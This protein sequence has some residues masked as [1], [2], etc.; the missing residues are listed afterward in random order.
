MSGTYEDNEPPDFEGPGD[1][2]PLANSL[3]QDGFSA[4]DGIPPVLP[5]YK[6]LPGS[7]VPVSSKRGK[8]W[9]ARKD[10]GQKAM[11]DL[12][13]AWDECI[14]YY[15]HDQSDHREGSDNRTAGNRYLARRLNDLFSST[16]NVVFSNVN[17]QVPELY[18]KNPIITCTASPGDQEQYR[19]D[20]E[21]FARAVEKLVNVLFA[22]KAAPG[23]GLKTKGKRAVLVAL[24]TNMAWF[25]IG[26]VN[27]DQSSEQALSDL[28]RLS[29]T[30]REAESTQEIE[31]TEQELRAL[32]QRIEFL[33]PSGPFLRLRLPHQ[34]IVDPD[35]TDPYLS[36][37]SWVMIED[38]LPTDYINAVY[39]TSNEDVYGEDKKAGSGDSEE[40]RS[41]FEP[42]H[43]LDG[44]GETDID[45]FTLFSQ[46]KN[47]YSAYGFENQEA[48][49]KAKR[50]KVWYAWDKSTQRLEMYTDADWKWPVW[51][52]DDPYQ[53]QNF[54][55]LTP[56]WFHD[57][58]N[59]VYAKGEVSYYLDQQ[60]QINEINDEKRR[61]LLWARRN[62]FYDSESGIT[63]ETADRILKG[64]DATATP[65]KVP[66]GKDPQ[67]L[68]FS[69][70]PPSSNFAPLFVKDDLYKA[71]DRIASTS[72]VERGGEF[73]TNTTNKAIDYYSTMGNMR[74]DMRLDAIE[75]AIADIGWKLAQ[76]CL[77]FM[78]PDTVQQLT[79]LDVSK[80]WRPL[81]NLS[82]FAK[83]SVNVVGGSTQKVS[84]QAKKQQAVQVGQVLSQYVKAAPATTLRVT[85]RMFGNAFD[86]LNLTKEDFAGIAD[87][88]AQTLVA[89]QGGAPGL[90]AS[91]GGAPPPGQPQT[92][93]APVQSGADMQGAG[94]GGPPPAQMAA[95]VT[96]VL[97]QLPPQVL[98]A[99]G[100]AL[101]QGAPPQAILQ[102][103]LAVTGGGQVGGPGG[104]P[105]MQQPNGHLQ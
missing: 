80:F 42:T 20:G 75:D 47:T 58:P 97:G 50:T 53:L 74:M 24:L 79:G 91:G 32:E 59:T 76:L 66:E 82:D 96:Q 84:S 27:K 67:K 83:F 65:I 92:Q 88:V 69:I 23:I 98:R 43:I 17:A 21:D 16:E 56:L 40:I 31:E 105:P 100:V 77:R 3:A 45:N 90:G 63:Q 87:E 28:Q 35:F 93:P 13:D 30:M 68:V 7:R 29:D 95:L 22:M 2:D 15:N 94:G 10:T 39:G 64:P 12:I 5:V 19:A 73:K 52:W 18:A 57:A 61:A 36:D 86:G 9:K 62:I 11:S 55:P 103:M 54:F 26:Y 25:E 44:G 78:S 72:E 71:I 33:Q 70:T 51:V 99:I 101:A 60:D 4:D 34:V 8:V 49:D 89:G 14:R 41:I 46:D 85:L 6:M 37:A 102:Q 48:Y 104:A 81:N 1:V 38:M